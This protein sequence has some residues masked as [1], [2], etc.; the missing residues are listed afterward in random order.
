M[1]ASALDG[2]GFSIKTF[3]NIYANKLGIKP[4]VLKKTLWGDYYYNAKTKRIMKGAQVFKIKLKINWIQ[5]NF[6]IYLESRKETIVCSV[7]PRKP[8]DD[9][10]CSLY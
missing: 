3:A 10:R 1:F 4:D 2:F 6:E 8:M 9:L 5:F 7:N